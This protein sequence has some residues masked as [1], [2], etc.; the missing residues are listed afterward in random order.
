[1]VQLR[2]DMGRAV[3]QLPPQQCPPSNLR[4]ATIPGYSTGPP[5]PKAATIVLGESSSAR[6]EA[7]IPGLL[8]LEFTN[9]LCTACRPGSLSVVAAR[10]DCWIRW[11]FCRSAATLHRPRQ[12]L[13]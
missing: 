2:L 4:I 13:C 8:Q 1:M 9:V 6:L 12:P 3:L 7:S 5:A 10:G 11:L